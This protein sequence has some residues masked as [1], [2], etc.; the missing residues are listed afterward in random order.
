MSWFRNLKL[1]QKLIASFL[2]CSVI[3]A[4]GV[5]AQAM[6]L[7]QEA[8]RFF[9]TGSDPVAGKSPVRAKQGHRSAGG[10]RKTASSARASELDESSFGRF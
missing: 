6:R 2:A 5:Y 10:L 4:T 1:A 9:D 8:N 7:L 3:T